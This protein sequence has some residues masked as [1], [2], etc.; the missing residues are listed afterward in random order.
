MSIAEITMTLIFYLFFYLC[1]CLCLQLKTKFKNFVCMFWTSDIIDGNIT[2]ALEFK[3]T[4]SFVVFY[5][6][7]FHVNKYTNAY[8]NV[9]KLRMLP[10]TTWGF[11]KLHFHMNLSSSDI[12]FFWPYAWMPNSQ[13]AQTQVSLYHLHGVQRTQVNL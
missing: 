6:V 8:R 13:V 3:S 1:I 10:W 2:K 5:Y 9:V 12:N 4:I 7:Y 11:Q